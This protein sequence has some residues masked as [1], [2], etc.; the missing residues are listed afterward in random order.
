MA[1]FTW[2]PSRGYTTKAKPRVFSATFGDGYSQRVS[3]GINNIDY[4]WTLNFSSISV[5]TAAE[6]TTFLAS[7]KGATSFTWNTT[8]GDN[9]TEVKVICSSWDESYDS[10]ISRSIQAEFVRVYDI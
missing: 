6:I 9:A 8:P 7:K 1:D 3:D 5:A 2:V 4:S 10:H